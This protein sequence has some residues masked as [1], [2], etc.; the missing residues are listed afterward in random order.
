MNESTKEGLRTQAGAEAIMRAGPQQNR[1]YW[2]VVA[3]FGE[4]GSDLKFAQELGEVASCV[5]P[6][7]SVLEGCAILDHTSLLCPENEIAIF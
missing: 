1:N 5:Y 4:L 3:G 7:R 6:S 2:I